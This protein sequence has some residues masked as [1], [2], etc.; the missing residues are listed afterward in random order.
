M[1]KICFVLLTI[2]L[3]LL[4]FKGYILVTETL[5][6]IGFG[7]FNSFIFYFFIVY[8]PERK[9]KKYIKNKMND[10]FSNNID[11]FKSILFSN[12]IKFK[13][14]ELKNFSDKKFLEKLLTNICCNDE[15]KTIMSDFVKQSDDWFTFL[16]KIKKTTINDIN[17]LLSIKNPQIYKV[18]KELLEIKNFLNKKFKLSNNDKLLSYLDVFFDYYNLIIKLKKFNKFKFQKCYIIN[19]CEFYFPIYYE[20]KF[21]YY[22]KTYFI[23]C[24]KIHLKIFKILKIKHHNSYKL[25]KQR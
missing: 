23:K 1:K 11:I 4:I 24:N 2:I 25:K 14:K 10:I 13:K 3:L 8:L 5:K 19:N 15:R 6:I 22:H 16:N 18:E 12:N 20:F 17:C 7:V 9:T 21:P